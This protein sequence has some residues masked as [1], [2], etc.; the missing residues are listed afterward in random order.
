MGFLEDTE[1]GTCV[2]AIV[3]DAGEPSEVL[4]AGYSYD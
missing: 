4:F 1:R 2:Y 3:Y